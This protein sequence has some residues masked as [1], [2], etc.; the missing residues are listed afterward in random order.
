M[1]MTNLKMAAALLAVCVT[2]A[3]PG[4]LVPKALPAKPDEADGQ[5]AQERKASASAAG[6]A[7]EAG[8]SLREFQ[9]LH[10]Q[11]QEPKDEPWLKIPWK[12][13]LTE[14]RAL[15]I[16]E[17]KPIFLFAPDGHPLGCT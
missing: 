16:K 4:W 2:L 3:G 1:L 7:A 6:K 13:S 17:S 5:G 8:L 10:R 14:A 9:D 11:L 15:A 12:L